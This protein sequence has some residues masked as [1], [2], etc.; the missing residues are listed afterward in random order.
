MTREKKETIMPQEFDAKYYSRAAYKIWHEDRTRFND[1]DTLGHV[2]SNRMQEFFVSART[3]LLKTILPEWPQGE[4]ITMLKLSTVSHEGELHFP[5]RVETGLVVERISRTSFTL[6]LGTFEEDRC[7][8]VTKN[9]F[10]FIDNTSR[11]PAEP[12]AKTVEL[13][14]EYA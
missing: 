10:V 13:M 7:I 8:A 5:A 12:T 9:V 11:R 3:I 4:I 1:L 6:M 2:N 14:R